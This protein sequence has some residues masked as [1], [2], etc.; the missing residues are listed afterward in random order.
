MRLIVF[1]FLLL[2][3]IA[4]S[5]NGVHA[6]TPPTLISTPSSDLRNILDATREK[7]SESREMMKAK[8]GEFRE[9]LQTIRD[10]KKKL[11]VERVDAKMESANQRTTTRFSAVLDKLQSVLNRLIGKAG[12]AKTKGIDTAALDLA[13][14]SAQASIGNAKTAVASQ[15]AKLYTIEIASESALR[16]SVG[17]VVNQLRQDLRDVHTAIVDAKQAVQKVAVEYARLRRNELN[18]DNTATS[19]SE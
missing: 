11:I 5:P 8:R 9:R 12:D 15:A 10:E 1:L 3:I 17:S 18:R 6:L 2:S 4:I 7:R 19:S 14:E 13:I 16:N